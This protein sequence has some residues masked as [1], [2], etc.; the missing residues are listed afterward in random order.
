M[1]YSKKEKPRLFSKMGNMC[2]KFFLNKYF[3]L[4]LFCAACVVCV[5]EKEVVG[6]FAF[7]CLICLC[8]VLCDDILASALPFLL[9]CVFVTKC[10]DS[11]S[12]FMKYIWMVIPAALSLAFHIIVYRKKFTVGKSIWGLLAV[13]AAITLGGVGLISGGEYFS[14][15]ALYHNFFLGIGMVLVYLWLKSELSAKRD[16]DVKEKLIE[17]LYVMGIFTCFMVLFNVLPMTTFKDGIQI[18]NNFQPSNNTCT[19]LMFALPAPFFYVKKSRLHLVAPFFMVACMI[20]GGSRSGV[21]FGMAELGICLLASAIWDK[22][23]RFLYVCL[24]VA[25]V[26][27]AALLKSKIIEV[28]QASNMYPI[29]NSEETR[30]QLIERAF[31]MFKKN[32][33]FGHG[34]GYQG[35]FDIYNPKSGAMGW[36]HM[37]IPQIIGSMGIV[38][39]AA[40]LFQGAMH[41]RIV[42][43]SARA[44]RKEG[45]GAVI[46]LTLSY[47]GVLMMSQVNPGLFCPLPYGLMATVI[48]AVMD[49]NDG[50]APVLRVWK[51][52]KKE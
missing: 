44:C 25:L 11:A 28:L 46:T 37:M 51:R 39:I 12:V 29:V 13:A 22:K 7:V 33:V 20:L 27:A 9:L 40:Y 36:Y 8:L 26:A 4:F 42:A 34:L 31:D 5:L 32:P 52:L 10:Y 14:G 17:L 48:F 1:I 6:A 15:S 3:S 49:G 16:Y 19:F 41:I 24:T 30:V 38:G 21:L 50:F 23:R 35:N 43:A 2:S 47:V 18:T 45:L